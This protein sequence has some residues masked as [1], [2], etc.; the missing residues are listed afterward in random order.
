MKVNTKRL[1]A[2]LKTQDYEKIFKALDIPIYSK[3][4]KYW[5]LYTACHHK[6]GY[7]GS[8]KL[9]Y[10]PSTGF[11]Q[12]LTQC[13]AS[14][15]II[16]LV[17]RR[18]AIL[19]KSSSF[20]DSIN[21]ILEIT[22]LEIEDVKRLNKP[23]VCNWQD[24]LE[25]F[26]RFRQTGTMSKVFDKSI[27]QSLDKIYP[28]GWIDEGI[29]IET[30][31]KYQIGYYGRS[32]CTTIPCFD[33]EGNLIGIRVRN[34]NP[35]EISGRKYMPLILMNGETYQFPTNNT[36]YNINW[37]WPEIERTGVVTLVEGEKSCMKA[38]TWYGNKSNV[39]A[40]Y[41]SQI[42]MFRR[43]QL[44]QMGVHEINLALDSDYHTFGDEDY[45]KFEAKMIK[46]AKLFQGYAKVNVI[47]NNLGLDGYK[48]SPF[49]FDKETFEKLY[50]NREEVN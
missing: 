5:S 23:N 37:V 10:Y 6:N 9:L 11:F 31:A 25:K 24:G 42:G 46:L 39:L 15:D 13:S 34:W 32:Q 36:F 33:K 12:C 17:Q 8:P 48:C 19:N 49:D 4:Q 2:N 35:E 43:N 44:I 27:L 41:G 30:M 16:A 26:I 38:D 20:M 40:L 18:L 28:Q 50:A 1:K 47:Y 14:F 21:T 29:S 45:I 3:G 22:G 7:D